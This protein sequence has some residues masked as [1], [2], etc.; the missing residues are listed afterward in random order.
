MFGMFKNAQEA[1]DER[2]V[3]EMALEQNQAV[4]VME[5]SPEPIL[6]APQKPQP[7]SIEA[8][9]VVRHEEYESLAAELGFVPTEIA[10]QKTNE[11]RRSVVEFILE[12]GWPVFDRAQVMKYLQVFADA[13]TDKMVA[14]W[15]KTSATKI[16]VDDYLR[17]GG[18]RIE[19]VWVA[20]TAQKMIG[21]NHSSN[22]QASQYEYTQPGYDK[23]IP[24]DILKRVKMLKDKFADTV[25]FTVSDYRATNPD[26]FIAVTPTG[27]DPI[28]FGVWD[29]PGWGVNSK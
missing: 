11:L 21:Y 3:Q 9:K 14:A 15:Q 8:P 29:E 2:R 25:T 16:S 17:R 10:Q 27:S 18:S 1:S 13:E 22:G 7:I 28:I 19:V 23:L 4:A 6:E 20:L 12:K 5:R 24:L 26:P